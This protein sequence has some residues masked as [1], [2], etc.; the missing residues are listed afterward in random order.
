LTFKGVNYILCTSDV[1]ERYYKEFIECSLPF[2][3]MAFI[4]ADNK[5]NLGDLIYKSLSVYGEYMYTSPIYGEDMEYQ[6]ELLTQVAELVEKN[7]IKSTKNYEY[8]FTFQDLCQALTLQHSGKAIG[9]I[10]LVRQ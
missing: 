2:G 6:N 10:V 4:A 8:A 1:T 7:V 9:K 5:V 3:K